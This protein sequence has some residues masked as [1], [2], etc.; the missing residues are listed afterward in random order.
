MPKWKLWKQKE[1][2][3]LAWV[4]SAEGMV[5]VESGRLGKMWQVRYWN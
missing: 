5:I 4:S 1:E 2:T 3:D